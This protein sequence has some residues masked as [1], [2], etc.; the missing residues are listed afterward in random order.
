MGS[1]YADRNTL[2]VFSR[3]EWIGKL[4]FDAALFHPELHAKGLPDCGEPFR[5]T[6]DDA[7]VRWIGEELVR[8]PTQR[9]FVSVTTLNSHLPI[10]ADADTAAILKCGTNNA[11]VTDEAACDLMSMVVK[12][13]RAVTDVALRQ[14]LPQTEFLIVGD[15]APPFTFKK[16]RALFSQTEVPFVHLM[17][18]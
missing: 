4:G 7:I 6:C 18:R 15:H 1:R 3:K 17:P 9:H 5:G 10:D 12:V 14:D 8:H 16:R 11:L 2:C 13:E